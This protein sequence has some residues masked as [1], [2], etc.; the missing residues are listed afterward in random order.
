LGVSLAATPRYASSVQLF[1][2]ALS[3]AHETD[4]GAATEF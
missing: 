2:S 4:P 1:L 3:A